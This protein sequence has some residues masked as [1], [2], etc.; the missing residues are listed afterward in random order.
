M[1]EETRVGSTVFE[2]VE[3]VFD[4]RTVTGKVEGLGLVG[5]PSSVEDVARS[6]FL[7]RRVDL[8]R[9]VVDSD[10]R[11]GDGVERV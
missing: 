7:A 9:L 3:L 6:E 10:A 2:A 4:V 11:R 5:D 1:T 8:L